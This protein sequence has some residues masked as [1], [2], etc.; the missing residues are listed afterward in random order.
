MKNCRGDLGV[1]FF[2][3][4]FFLLTEAQ[5]AIKPE[6]HLPRFAGGI[7][8]SYTFHSMLERKLICLGNSPSIA[9]ISPVPNMYGHM[10]RFSLDSMRSIQAI[11][12]QFKVHHFSMRSI[13]HVL[14]AVDSPANSLKGQTIQWSDKLQKPKSYISDF[15][16]LIYHVKC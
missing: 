2:S 14:P 10:K 11:S 16:D 12:K 9:A 8:D 1:L 3:F 4:L 13:I 15:P 7:I 5:T 6:N